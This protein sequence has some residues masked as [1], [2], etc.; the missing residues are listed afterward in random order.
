MTFI[1]VAIRSPSPQPP[2]LPGH[3]SRL[4]GPGGGIPALSL[5]SSMCLGGSPSPE[6]K[7]HAGW[8]LSILSVIHS[9]GLGHGHAAGTQQL[10]NE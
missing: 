10:L 5:W 7:L 2:K 6:Q 4:H 8:A 9:Q 1:P 3:F